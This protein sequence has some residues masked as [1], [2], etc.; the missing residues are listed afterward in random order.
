MKIKVEVRVKVEKKKNIIKIHNLIIG[1]NVEVIV[2]V[3]HFVFHHHRRHLRLRLQ[4]KYLIS[5]CGEYKISHFI[6]LNSNFINQ[7]LLCFWIALHY[8]IYDFIAHF[9]TLTITSHIF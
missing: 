5:L 3:R 4:L 9:L 2:R 8:G 6:C 7:M 1:M